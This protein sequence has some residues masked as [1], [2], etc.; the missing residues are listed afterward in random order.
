MTRFVLVLGLM[1]G[2]LATSGVA[3]AQDGGGWNITICHY[4]SSVGSWNPTTVG[5][6]LALIY[7][8]FY[9]DALPGG[10]TSSTNTELDANCEPVEEDEAVQLQ[11][12]CW[13]D[14]TDVELVEAIDEYDPVESY[15]YVGLYEGVETAVFDYDN[16]RSWYVQVYDETL[17]ASNCFARFSDT[18][19]RE[20]DMSSVDDDGNALFTQDDALACEMELE[21]YI[22]PAAALCE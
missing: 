5:R 9:D 20:L 12:P 4:D 14:Y 6:I 3:R 7:L 18:D 13:D 2:G 11:C 22:I 19:E 10:T 17:S 8:W 15:C 21:E 16:S 1:V